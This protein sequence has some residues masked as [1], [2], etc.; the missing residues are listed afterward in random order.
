[1]TDWNTHPLRSLLF[2]PGSDQGKLAKAGTYGA[3]AVVIDLEDAVADDRKTAARD[4]TRRM[5]TA[6]G[7][8][9]AVVVRV[10]GATSGLMEDD[11][12]AIVSPGLD[13]IVVPKV[14]D[15][16]TLERA[17]AAITD[18]EHA[19]GTAI[20][21][22]R[23][24]AVIETARGIARC[25][26]VLAQAPARVHTAI[27]GSGDLSSELGIDL[28]PDATEML[29][30]RSR[31]VI[32][33]RAAGLA[34][35]I[36]GPW[37][38]LDDVQGLEADSARSRQLGFQGRVALHPC[39]IQPELDVYSALTEREAMRARKIVEAYE[40]SERNGVGALR[41]DGTFVDYPFYR[42]ARDRIHRYDSWK[43]KVR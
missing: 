28:T 34:A 21:T 19:A 10:N 11:V 18:A 15:V 2:V 14:E 17:D 37:L 9:H 40:E 13:A 7:E 42:L 29:Y 41:V 38:W 43:A 3:D 5:M 36:D 8:D 35:P 23:L 25:E 39:Q 27:L 22:I 33:A 20:G 30:A 31:T 26:T 24:L 4:T 12:A 6:F 32:A 1:M 16:E